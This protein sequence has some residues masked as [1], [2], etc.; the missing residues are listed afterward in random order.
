MSSIV[1]REE[2]HV[3]SAHPFVR[4]SNCREN[5]LSKGLSL[6]IS[7][8]EVVEYGGIHRHHSLLL[9]VIVVGIDFWALQVVRGINHDINQS[10][11]V[12]GELSKRLLL[13]SCTNYVI[14]A[15]KSIK[16][17]SLVSVPVIL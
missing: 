17:L 11:I 3:G 2:A 9:E 14:R 10:S 16:L 5:P 4:V 15:Y 1:S 12:A 6:S 7:A 13:V 8:E